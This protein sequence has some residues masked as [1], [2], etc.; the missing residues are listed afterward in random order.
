[1]TGRSKDWELEEKRLY[2]VHEQIHKKMEQ[3]SENVGDLKEGIIGLRKTFW[4]DVTVNLDDAHEVGET[5]TSIKQQTEL[6]SERERTH[7]Q[8]Y[9]QMRKLLK[10][11]DSAYFGRIDFL[12]VGESKEEEVYV[13]IAS[14][15]DEKDEDFLVYDWRAPISSLYYNYSPG[16]AR[17]E[18]P[19]EVIEGEVTLKRQYIIDHGKLKSMFDTGVTI[20]DDLLQEVLSNNANTEMKNIVATIQKEQNEIIRNEKSRFLFVQGVAGSGKTSAAL[21]RVAY[22][23]YTYRKSLTADNIM[24]FSPNLLFNSYISTVLP[25]L[26]EENMKQMTFQ[27]YLE[28]RIGSDYHL[29]DPFTQME[30]LYTA[31]GESDY[32]LRLKSIQFKSSIQFRKYIDEYLTLLSK[33]MLLFHPLYFRGELFISE[34]EIEKYFYELDAS[35][36]ISNRM[37]LLVE[38]L[39][40]EVKKLEKRERRKDWPIEE[41]E[42]LD[43]E[44]YLEA[45]RQSQKGGR[46]KE[47][48]FDDFDREEKVLVKMIV[49][50]HL[51]PLKK[52]IKG[53]RFLAI[54]AMYRQ[55]FTSEVTHKL[56]ADGL[57]KEW[58]D[59]ADIT[60]RNLDKESLYYEDATAFLYLRDQLEGKKTYTTIKHVLIDEAQDYSLFQFEYLKQLFPHSRMTILG[61]LNQAIYAHSIGGE[62][63]LSHRESDLEKIQQITL[64][65]SYRSTQQIVHFSKGL[66]DGGEHIIPFN[67]SGSLPTLTVV[68]SDMMLK[69][70]ITLCAEQLIRKGNKTIAI[71]CKTE[72]ESEEAYHLF[73]NELD[74]HLLN[75]DSHT[76]KEGIL[77]MPAYLSK[78]IEF[79]AVIIYNASNTEYEHDLERRLFYTACTRAMHELHIYSLGKPTNFFKHVER[80]SYSQR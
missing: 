74:V 14:L 27:S 58:N 25:E 32:E 26:G 16:K 23:L 51:L 15:M 78:G 22:L 3:L 29:E 43:K 63:L 73:K 4:D 28:E 18:V 33:E 47:D 79:D 6:L 54:K 76:Y 64:L 48:T 34:E 20:G 77:I 55:L 19:S 50:K 17:Y 13:G 45:Y 39:L 7:K 75:K 62:T 2:D 68:E 41:S 42:L 21:Q 24:L 44:D 10:L 69:K 53:Y 49:K 36:P 59:V 80:G 65:K 5:F 38:W 30:Y 12:E 61:D 72:K 60:V 1:M 37:N 31:R 40:L 52:A 46:H 71:L 8:A 9:D 67:R 70:Q 35:L 11:K 57:P 66:I 56:C